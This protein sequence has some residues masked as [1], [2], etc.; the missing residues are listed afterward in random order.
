MGTACTRVHMAGV[1][2]NTLLAQAIC[3]YRLQVSN[4]VK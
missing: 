1:I 3:M 2:Q 4:S